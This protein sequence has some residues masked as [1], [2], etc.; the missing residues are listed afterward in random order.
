ME[1]TG[2]EPDVIAYDKK[3]DEY[4]F[5]DCSEQSPDRRSICYD[6][7]GEKARQ[8]KGVHPGGNAVDLA[9]KMGVELLN[10]EQY[11]TLQELGEF[12]TTTSSW[13]KTPQKIRD[14]GGAI[15]GD[16]RYDTVFVYHNGAES[17]YAARGFRGIL[18][19]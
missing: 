12:D 18:K 13:L 4:T 11:R 3:A 2:G 17:F 9:E 15:F 14:L 16:R 6:G 8:K 19:I 1:S 5:C 7:A 10:K